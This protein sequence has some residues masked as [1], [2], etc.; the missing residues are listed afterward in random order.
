[1]YEL[2][3]IS[4]WFLCA[5]RPLRTN[6]KYIATDK[7]TFRGGVVAYMIDGYWYNENIFNK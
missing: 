6:T 7:R 3:T 5:Y 1:M 2:T 4:T